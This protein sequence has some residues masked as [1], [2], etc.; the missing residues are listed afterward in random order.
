M[1][2]DAL[3]CV[4]VTGYAVVSGEKNI[5]TVKLDSNLALVWIKEYTS[6]GNDD[7]GRDVACG[8]FGKCFCGWIH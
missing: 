7:V 6:G 3:N 1:T 8:C 4:Y 5:Q 2:T